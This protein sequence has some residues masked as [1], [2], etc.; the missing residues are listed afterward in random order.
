MTK[1]LTYYIADINKSLPRPPPLT[2]LPN[3]DLLDTQGYLLPNEI[4]Q[5][6]TYL[7]TVTD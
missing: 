7:E 2:V 1:I 6:V 5:P 3:V 4:K